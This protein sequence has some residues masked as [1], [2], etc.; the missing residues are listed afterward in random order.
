MVPYTILV[1]MIVLYVIIIIANF[2]CLYRL[3]LTLNLIYITVICG[4]RNL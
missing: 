3:L 2:H 1:I 4:S